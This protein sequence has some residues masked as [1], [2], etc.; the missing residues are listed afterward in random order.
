MRNRWFHKAILHS[1]A[2][3]LE[4]KVTWLELFYDLIF[5]A[6]FIQLGNGLSKNVTP[7]NVALFCGLFIPLWVSW[8]GFSFFENRY[9]V[10][11]FLHRL[12]VLA[13]MGA[14]GGMAISAPQVLEGEF[15]PFAIWA[16][17][18]MSLVGFM[19]RGPTSRNRPA[20][21]MPDIGASCSPSAAPR[22]LSVVW[23]V[24]LGS[25]P[26]T[27]APRCADSRRSSSSLRRS[28]STRGP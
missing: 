21:R 14:V 22:G 26:S 3:G 28:T 7:G 16:G 2:L 27:W 8:T 23:W 6:A 17:V 9:S 11:D 1:P 20:E 15:Y 25:Y 10:D 5:V 4:K 24:R 12:T 18:A 19:M 13:Q